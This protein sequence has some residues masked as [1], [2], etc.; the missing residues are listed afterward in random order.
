MAIGRSAPITLCLVLSACVQAP[1]RQEEQSALVWPAEPDVARVAYVRSFARAEDL[2]ISGGFFER[3][4]SIL[5][6]RDELRLVRPMAVTVVG[7]NIFVADP[8]AMG[9]HRFDLEQHR[10]D[11]LRPADR[12]LPSPVGLARGDDGE[13]YV[14]DSALGSV[15]VIAPGA[16]TAS[17]LPLGAKLKQPTG[18]T[19]DPDRH[20]LYV[21]D[22]AAHRVNVF[23]RKGALISGFGQRGS[24]DGEFNFPTHLW[25]DRDGRLYVTDA[26]NFRL[27]MFDGQGRFLG[28]FGRQGDGTG[29][30][31]RQKGV[32]TDGF[33]HI[34]IVDA[35]FHALQVFDGEGRLLLSLGGRGHDRGEFWL[36]AGIFISDDN[37]IYVA[38][39]Y[40]QRVQVLRYVG[41][42]T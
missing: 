24:A 38:D 14:T 18:I 4:A 32:A 37:T 33:G 13:V 34:Y 31:A 30:I 2:G 3:L 29:D 28:K 22:T 7:Q 36:P 23:D 20:H 21:V 26:L 39:S 10:Y 19:F 11:L 25:R 9:V 15:F 16:K 40:N 17:P 42:P 41:G 12:A 1:V 8:G 27:Q 5:L 35:L 6:G